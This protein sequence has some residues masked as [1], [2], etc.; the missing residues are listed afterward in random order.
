MRD[1]RCLSS[2]LWHDP[3]LAR[4]TSFVTGRPSSTAGV[5]AGC[6]P[7]GAGPTRISN[8]AETIQLRMRM[9]NPFGHQQ[10]KRARDIRQRNRRAAAAVVVEQ[11]RQTPV[12][13]SHFRE[14]DEVHVFDEPQ[15]AL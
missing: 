15:P 7:T 3:H 13:S 4:T 6:A 8:A 14:R 1:M 9:K 2:L 11:I 5:G 12:A 10:R